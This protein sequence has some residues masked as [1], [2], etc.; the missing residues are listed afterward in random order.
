MAPL[1]PFDA[2]GWDVSCRDNINKLLDTWSE[3]DKWGSSAAT[4]ITALVPL[5]ISVWGLPTA[6]ILE[7]YLVDE[8]LVAVITAGLTFALP[9]AIA[10]TRGYLP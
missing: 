10:G 7:L 2:I 4:T 6:D 8:H 1:N 9:H 5:L 3:Y